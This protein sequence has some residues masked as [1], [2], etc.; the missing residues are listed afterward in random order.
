MQGNSTAPIRIRGVCC[1]TEEDSYHC[2]LLC[3]GP[4]KDYMSTP[5]KANFVT[6]QNSGLDLL[7][8]IVQYS[9]PNNNQRTS[10]YF[11]GPL[12]VNSFADHLKSIFYL[13]SRTNQTCFT[14][15]PRF[16][17]SRPKKSYLS[18]SQTANVFTTCRFRPH[19]FCRA[20][21]E[22]HRTAEARTAA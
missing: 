17:P 19:I 7:W 21:L 20:Y 5:R 11:S 1:R 9:V 14:P 4:V 3:V 22:N 16:Q 10:N 12:R 13:A 2:N 18:D 15:A 6:F 8:A